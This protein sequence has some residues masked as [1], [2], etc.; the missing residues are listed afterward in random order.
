MDWW[1]NER[2]KLRRS[3]VSSVQWNGN[4]QLDTNIYVLFFLFI[5]NLMKEIE[6]A[7]LMSLILSLGR[8]IGLLYIVNPVHYISIMGFPHFLEKEVTIPWVLTTQWLHLLNY[9]FGSL[10]EWG[11]QMKPGT[12]W[13]EAEQTRVNSSNNMPQEEKEPSYFHC[14]LRE[15]QIWRVSSQLPQQYRGGNDNHMRKTEFRR[16]KLGMTMARTQE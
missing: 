16:Y 15:T 8:F 14:W 2:Q 11:N 1:L 12:H 10:A 13:L 3:I 6:A 7:I 9:V 5:A 4:Y